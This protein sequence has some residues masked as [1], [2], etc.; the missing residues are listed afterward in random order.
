[1][2]YMMEGTSFDAEKL[3]IYDNVVKVVAGV[4]SKAYVYLKKDNWEELYAKDFEKLASTIN[5]VKTSVN[6]KADKIPI[7]SD[8]YFIK[9]NVYTT[10]NISY[11]HSFK[12]NLADIIDPSTYNEYIIE[13]KCT[14]TPSSVVFVD[15]NY[16]EIDIKWANGIPPTFEA[17][18]TYLISIVNGY[19]L[20]TKF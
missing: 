9:P 18:N 6:A 20:Y 7:E 12:F 13:I 19:G 17:G 3:L 11:V 2:L 16:T 15:S 5:N 8:S 10:R 1:M 4:P 14:A